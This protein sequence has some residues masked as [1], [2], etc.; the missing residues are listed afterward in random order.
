ML[1][2]T[3]IARKLSLM[4]IQITSSATL[5]MSQ[6]HWKVC[7]LSGENC[8]PGHAVVFRGRAEIRHNSVTY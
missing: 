1:L 7:L 3:S 2:R 6:Y 8:Y 4:E 5:A